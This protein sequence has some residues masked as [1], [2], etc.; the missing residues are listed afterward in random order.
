MVGES[1]YI[2]PLVKSHTHRLNLS[3]S[4]P[5]GCRQTFT[6]NVLP[7]EKDF[8]SQSLTVGFLRKVNYER[9]TKTTN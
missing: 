3:G 2:F 7:R 6:D 9:R 8:S 4:F 1:P 5:S